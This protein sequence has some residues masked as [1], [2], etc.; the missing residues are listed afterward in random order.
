MGKKLKK[1]LK[2]K[3][4]TGIKSLATLKAGMRMNTEQQVVFITG[5]LLI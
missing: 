4:M 1:Y 3:Y 5:I 2:K